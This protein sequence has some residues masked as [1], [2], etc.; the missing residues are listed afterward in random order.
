MEEQVKIGVF[1]FNKPLME[2]MSF[3]ERQSHLV[4]DQ[5]YIL[6]KQIVKVILPQH[7][8]FQFQMLTEK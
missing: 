6:L 5:K 7:S 3:Q 2:D 1:P 8:I 4:M